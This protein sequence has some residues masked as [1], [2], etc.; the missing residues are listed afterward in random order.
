MKVNKM[1]EKDLTSVEILGIGA[2]SEEESFK[3]YKKL[4]GKVK[5]RIVKEKLLNLARDEKIHKE[6]LLKKYYETTGEKS[7]PLPPKGRERSKALKSEGMTIK[8]L[9]ELAISKE[10]DAVQLYSMGAAKAAD[11]S[12]KY[13]LEYLADFERNHERMLENE[14]KALERFPKWFEEEDPRLQSEDKT[15]KLEAEKFYKYIKKEGCM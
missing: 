8:E 15:V 3:L 12:G 11:L 7:P 2:R 6:I 1:I 13:M 4:A 10:R 14:L 5:N 9:I